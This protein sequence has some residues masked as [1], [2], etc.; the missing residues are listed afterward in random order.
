MTGENSGLVYDRRRNCCRHKWTDTLCERKLT[1]IGNFIRSSEQVVVLQKSIS[2]AAKT[3]SRSIVVLSP[4]PVPG[5]N[6]MKSTWFPFI[7]GL[8]VSEATGSPV[9]SGRLGVPSHSSHTHPT[10]IPHA[11]IVG[12]QC[13]PTTSQRVRQE[14]TNPRCRRPRQVTPSSQPAVRSP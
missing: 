3:K 9:R 11:S 6:A 13:T 4:T 2:L 1:K 8:A 10:R 12:G 7:A 14:I 5:T